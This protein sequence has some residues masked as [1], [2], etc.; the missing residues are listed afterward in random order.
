MALDQF[1]ERINGP[2]LKEK[3][4]KC[5]EEELIKNLKELHEYYWNLGKKLHAEGGKSP[6]RAYEAGE[7]SGA[8]QTVDTILL[9]VI[10]GKAMY[11]I[12]ENNWNNG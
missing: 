1:V 11:Q 7:V 5:T 9:L 12:L 3:N 10:G 2:L 8:L 4:M 6:N